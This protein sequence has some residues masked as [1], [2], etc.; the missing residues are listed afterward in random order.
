[1]KTFSR[2]VVEIQFEGR[3]YT[4]HVSKDGFVVGRSSDC[5]VHI[6]S[7]NLSRQHMR[8]SL[9][10]SEIFIEDLKSTNGCYLNGE[11]IEP[12]KLTLY[13]ADKV[14]TL[15]KHEDV[16][17]HLTAEFKVVKEAATA[18]EIKENLAEVFSKDPL[19]LKD[20][21]PKKAERDYKE[22]MNQVEI[23]KTEIIDR[24]EKRADKILAE[25]KESADKVVNDSQKKSE[26]IISQARSSA[27]KMLADAVEQSKNVKEQ[28]ELSDLLRQ[29]DEKKHEVERVNEIIATCRENLKS[30]ERKNDEFLKLEEKN[31]A[32]ELSI[33]SLES[34]KNGLMENQKDLEGQ[35]SIS[36]QELEK[37]L[38]EKE[39][40]KNMIADAEKQNASVLKEMNSR[41]NEVS[42]LS[43]V[44][45]KLEA[46]VASLNDKK[47]EVDALKA[48]IAEVQSD[49]DAKGS[50]FKNIL[51]EIQDVNTELKSL[52]DLEKNLQSENANHKAQIEL[53][54]TNIEKLKK[55]YD[56]F[57]EKQKS[58]LLEIDEINHKKDNSMH[59]LTDLQ[60]KAS[61]LDKEC[62]DKVKKA[63]DESDLIISQAKA[64]AQADYMALIEKS[65]Q[66]LA[67]KEESL[68]S[69]AKNQANDMVEKA[70]NEAQKI[71]AQAKKINDE[72]VA[73]A[74]A[75]ADKI[76]KDSQARADELRDRAQSE[77]QKLVK[78]A[79]TEADKIKVNAIQIM[80]EKKKDFVELEKKR[81]R[82]SSDLL[83]SELNV[84]LYSKLKL[85]LKEDNE[86]Y[87]A[88][89][90]TSL[91]TAINS[92]MLNE[93]L[94]NDEE[95]YAMLDDQVLKQQQKS[96]NYWRYTVPS[97]MVSLVVIYF[98]VP[99]FTK[100][101][102]DKSR[103][104]ASMTKQEAVERVKKKEEESKEAFFE[105]FDPK[106]TAEFKDN[107]TDRVLYTEKYAELVL[108][109]DYREEWILELQNFFVDEL[110]LSENALV[111]FISQEANMIRELI[112]Q[113]KKINGKFIEQ[114]IAKM[115]DIEADFIKKLKSHLNKDSDFKKI[116]NFQK[117]FFLKK[118]KQS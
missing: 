2:Y 83:K 56:E 96:K 92:S 35:I 107:Y 60:K 86:D 34:Q 67:D 72:M 91:E 55:E 106:R 6:D 105:F 23:L 42:K 75:K 78:Q 14:L 47:K 80:D 9:V 12:A 24:A 49:L 95:M 102:K 19:S 89:V 69:H 74:E 97:V 15:G 68:L 52:K 70:T 61:A 85:Y 65:K 118:V 45:A 26:D 37:F 17:V 77:Y 94:E 88:R 93:V 87:L 7:K 58:L 109:K 43:D 39:N 116:N 46:D 100:Q 25:A 21:A 10:G 16:I 53:E 81:I 32:L 30:L 111:P 76:F 66:D 98:A 101:I 64:K 40:I 44:K 108:T 114:G 103:E 79:E 27:D 29:I 99:F 1:M 110:E 18:K 57:F 31:T 5:D 71:D 117:K 82:K 41:E 59:E 11:Q 113:S 33:K 8:V 22:I 62:S 73:K 50:E 115:R 48:K 13:T 4:E 28:T 63:N 90:K 36:S 84:L 112:D 104:V 51:L 38:K 3:K 20:P 54:K